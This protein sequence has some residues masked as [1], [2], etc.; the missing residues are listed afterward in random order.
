MTNYHLCPTCGALVKSVGMPDFIGDEHPVTMHYEPVCEELVR[1]LATVDWMA[2]GYGK[3]RS[4]V[5]RAQIAVETID[6]LRA[7]Y[8]DTAGDGDGVFD[9]GQDEVSDD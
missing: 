9:S 6:E 1:E 8:R 7:R 5:V 3:A 2:Y 4:L